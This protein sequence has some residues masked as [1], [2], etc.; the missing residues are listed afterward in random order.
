LFYNF[1]A[2]VVVME[3]DA[4][5][6][7]GTPTTTTVDSSTCFADDDDVDNDPTYYNPGLDATTLHFECMG[8]NDAPSLASSLGAKAVL[9]IVLGAV[10]FLSM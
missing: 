8:S 9:A 7:A 3:Y 1:A 5:Y 6:C 4:V 2:S 10:A